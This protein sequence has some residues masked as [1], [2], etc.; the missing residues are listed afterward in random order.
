MVHNQIDKIP[1]HECQIF[2]VIEEVKHSFLKW[3]GHKNDGKERKMTKSV[4]ENYI[5]VTGE[6]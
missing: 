1:T 6:R 4:F 5:Q 2:I 3:F